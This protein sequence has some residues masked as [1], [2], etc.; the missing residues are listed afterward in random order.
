MANWMIICLHTSWCSLRKHCQNI[1]TYG[2]DAPQDV[3]VLW[4][5]QTICLPLKPR[6][7][8]ECINGICALP[9]FHSGRFPLLTAFLITAIFLGIKPFL[10]LI[11]KVFL[12]YDCESNLAVISKYTEE[13]DKYEEKGII[14]LV[15]HPERA[16]PTIPVKKPDGRIFYLFRLLLHNYCTLQNKFINVAFNCCMKPLVDW[17]SNPH[18]THHTKMR[19][20]LLLSHDTQMNGDTPAQY[21]AVLRNSPL[22]SW[23]WV[24]QPNGT[25]KPH[26]NS[27]WS[28]C[29]A[30]LPII[31]QQLP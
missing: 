8:V 30:R 22:I 5:M 18:W 15:T 23:T 26:Y 12:P 20:Y 13:L 9:R 21:S 11:L 1:S 4:L 3:C 7:W 17:L 6:L 28:A 16:S 29:D 25:H 10:P 2:W 31:T 24:T 14:I 27:D 19:I